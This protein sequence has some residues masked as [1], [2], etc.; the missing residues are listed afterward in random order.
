MKQTTLL[1]VAI[2][3][4]T[5]A[6]AEVRKGGK[7]TELSKIRIEES[8][9]TAKT[10]EVAVSSAKASLAQKAA[11]E[12]GNGAR[13]EELEVMMTK[14][15]E[16]TEVVETLAASSDKSDEKAILAYAGR[17]RGT[18]TDATQDN[19]GV[20]KIM[21]NLHQV[22]KVFGA[23]GKVLVAEMR[24]SLES[25]S[26]MNQALRDG[27]NASKGRKLSKVEADKVV[28]EELP[29]CEK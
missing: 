14:V 9:S 15:P 10:G 29:N 13:A 1:V 11:K 25:G 19:A 20:K 6:F 17:A 2:T 12:I 23:R 21:T 18:G 26:T 28:R 24:R 4:S 3:M 27:L 8:K 7:E 16:M 22:E 5:M